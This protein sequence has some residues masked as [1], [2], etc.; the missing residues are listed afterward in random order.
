[1]TNKPIGTKVIITNDCR[2]W[3]RATGKEGIIVKKKRYTI[4]KDVFPLKI[5]KN[6]TLHVTDLD[7]D[8]VVNV[9][10]I[11]YG[12][13]AKIRGYKCWWTTVDEYNKIKKLNKKDDA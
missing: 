2:K 8:L 4:S 12:R 9:P 6:T 11:K 1:M 10:V 7:K 13:F 3:K 5:N